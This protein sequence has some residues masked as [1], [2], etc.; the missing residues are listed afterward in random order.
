MLYL[1]EFVKKHHRVLDGHGE[2]V[3]DGSVMEMDLPNQMVVP[4]TS[5]GLAGDM[6]IGEEMH[7]Y[8]PDPIAFARVATA[9]FGVEAEVPR[10]IPP[11]PGLERLGKDVAY[12]REDTGIGGRVRSGRFPDGHLID[13]DDLVEVLMTGN[14]LEATVAVPRTRQEVVHHGRQCPVDKGGLPGT[15]HPGD[16][17]HR[18]QRYVNGDVLEV[19]LGRSLEME[20]S[21]RRLL[22]LRY[23]DLFLSSEEFRGLGVGFH[24]LLVGSLEHDT[25][26]VDAGARTDVDDLV[27]GAHDILVMLDNDDRVTEVHELTEVVD[28]EAAI[29]RMET[30]R[31][32]VQDI[33][34]ALQASSYLRREPDALRFT[35]G[36]GIG[37]TGE[38]HVSEAHP[39]QEFQ[40]VADVFQDVPGDL[41][42][43]LGELQTVEEIDG[44]LDGILGHMTDVLPIYDD[45]AGRFPDA[46]PLA[47]RT[48]RRYHEGVDFLMEGFARVRIVVDTVEI[49]DDAGIFCIPGLLHLWCGEGQSLFRAVEHDGLLALGQV[50]VEN[51]CWYFVMLAGSQQDEVVVGVR[52]PW[53]DAALLDGFLRIDDG[54]LR[55]A[56][57]GSQ[58]MTGRAG[59]GRRI[60]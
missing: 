1:R 27:R 21:G 5:A 26:S 8:A 40:T 29:A 49:G 55:E 56:Q 36:E 53:H 38:R 50:L 42:I 11:G 12:V 45:M 30:D 39:F 54:F 25:S 6:D 58:S 17:G 31:W 44:L 35:A 2:D 15:A 48:C 41:G 57:D 19:V 13:D 4:G 24:E 10:A 60:E 47:C 3:C 43:F 18:L 23:M 51:L 9:L 14:A 37:T 16:D 59:T 34:D 20:E 7:L 33:R 32:F 46:I 28:E 52:C 22:E